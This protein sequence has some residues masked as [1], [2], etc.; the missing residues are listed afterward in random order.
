M[1]DDV[2]DGDEARAFC[3]GIAFHYLPNETGRNTR[4]FVESYDF[5][6]RR[7]GERGRIDQFKFKLKFIDGNLDLE[8]SG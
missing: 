8:K 5:H 2:Y 1:G 4:V 3:Y 7:E 6:L